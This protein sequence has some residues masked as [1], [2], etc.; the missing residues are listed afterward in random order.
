MMSCNNR[1]PFCNFCTIWSSFAT[2]IVVTRWFNRAERP[3]IVARNKYTRRVMFAV[4]IRVTLAFAFSSIN[5]SFE[6]SRW[7]AVFIRVRL[8]VA[9]HA[10]CLR[11]SK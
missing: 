3:L 5:F 2:K 7:F 6:N 1:S 8:A 4:F 9:H 10:L 11:V